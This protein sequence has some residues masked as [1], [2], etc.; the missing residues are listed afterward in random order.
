MQEV[1]K[2]TGINNNDARLPVSTGVPVGVVSTRNYGQVVIEEN[3]VFRAQL[4]CTNC[5]F[6]SDSF[7][8]GYYLPNDSCDF[9]LQNTM[10]SSFRI[11]SCGDISRRTK[12]LNPSEQEMEEVIESLQ[13][14]IKREDE[15]LVDYWMPVDTFPCRICPKCH[16]RTVALTLL[17]IL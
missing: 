13:F 6:K 8:I 14:E 5:G 9:V 7:T 2:A 3:V 11:V 17:S 12:T 16:Q 1:L 10:D 15:E 4:V